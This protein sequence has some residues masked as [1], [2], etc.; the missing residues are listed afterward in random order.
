M[1][2]DGILQETISL[3]MVGNQDTYPLPTDLLVLR[4]I[5]VRKSATEPFRSIPFK[6]LAQFDLDMDTWDQNTFTNGVPFSYTEYDNNIIL[7]PKPDTTFIAGI[8][9]LYTKQPSDVSADIDE[10]N[11]PIQIGRAHV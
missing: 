1:N 8:K 7:F 11:I 2:N 3:D 10:L 4:S 5:R 6:S 9:V